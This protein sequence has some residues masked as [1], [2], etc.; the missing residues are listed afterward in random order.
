MRVSGVYKC[1]STDPNIPITPFPLSSSF[2]IDGTFKG[3]CRPDNSAP[4]A[5]I[6][7]DLQR[8]FYSSYKKYVVHEPR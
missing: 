2:Q 6:F 5:G 4:G 3:V 8:L 1:I 7:Q